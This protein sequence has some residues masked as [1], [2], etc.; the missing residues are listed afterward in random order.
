MVR[1][2][3]GYKA[4]WKV[5][6]TSSSRERC[7]IYF[8]SKQEDPGVVRA[9]KCPSQ[10]SDLETEHGKRLQVSGE[11]GGEGVYSNG[12]NPGER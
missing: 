9:E 11:S 6:I 12:D 2:T 8:Y 7:W 4:A 1:V 10:V 5:G 3:W